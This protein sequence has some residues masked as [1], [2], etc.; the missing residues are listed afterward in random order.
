[1]LFKK[2]FE[3]GQISGVH[4]GNGKN[5]FRNIRLN[6]YSFVADGVLIDTGS[7][8]LR[9]YF[10]PYFDEHRIEQVVLTHYHEDHTGGA[11]YLAEKGIPIY[12]N[13]IMRSYC[14]KEA[15][16]P[17]YR[18]I[19]WGKREPFEAQP[20]GQT[21]QSNS[22]TWDVIETP[23]HAVDHLAF[24]NRETGQL[25]TGDLYV[26]PKTKVILKEESIPTIISSL[27]KV[28]TYDFDEMFCCHAGYVK[29]GRKALVN[30]HDFLLTLQDQVITLNKEGYSNKEIANEL[31]TKK[32]PI[33]RISFGEWD[34]MHIINSILKG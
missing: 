19:F 16:Y 20:I 32:Y 6:V 23:G 21:F 26:M 2:N 34:S 27:E 17:F 14:M 30:K 1:M 11:A 10:I 9:N 18:K 24:L 31:F 29:D 22:A 3:K 33:S 8:S 12:M 5:V 4:F 28:L 13:D 15:D 25:F 7:A